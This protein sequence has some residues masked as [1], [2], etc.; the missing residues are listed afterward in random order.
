MR[1]MATGSQP[2]LPAALRGELTRSIPLR[3]SG[4]C[5]GQRQSVGLLA[6]TAERRKEG[7]RSRDLLELLIVRFEPEN[8]ELV[9]LPC[10]YQAVC[11]HSVI[12]ASRNA[13]NTMQILLRRDRPLNPVRMVMSD[14]PR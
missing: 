8:A 10:E 11:S 13:P 12:A 5:R 14:C 6:A 1:A 9:T 4:R 7:S 3:L 2:Q